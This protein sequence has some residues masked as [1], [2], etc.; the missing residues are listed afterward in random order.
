MGE[1]QFL[2]CE[3]SSVV[4]VVCHENYVRGATCQTYK[5][6]MNKDTCLRLQAGQ[7]FV[8]SNTILFADVLAYL[9]HLAII[10]N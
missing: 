6:Y 4:V 10:K 9:S 2:A 7:I 3:D 1:G 8:T 5:Y